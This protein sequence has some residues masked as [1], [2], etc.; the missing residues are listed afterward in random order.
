[1]RS[2]H[3][4]IPG[5]TGSITAMYPIDD[6]CLVSLR[7]QVG[8]DESGVP[9]WEYEFTMPVMCLTDKSAARTSIR[10]TVRIAAQVTEA[11]LRCGC[12]LQTDC[13][14]CP[15]SAAEISPGV[16]RILYDA[17]VSLYLTRHA[18]CS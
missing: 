3:V 13:L 9:L 11:N 12:I 1:M 14:V 5:L 8:A 10:F 18:F 7:G 16:Y 4:Y 15:Y 2:Q 17:H 6:R